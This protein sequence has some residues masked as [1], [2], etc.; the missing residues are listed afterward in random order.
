MSE[1][2]DEGVHEMI[3]FAWF[4]HN[5]HYFIAKIVYIEEVQ[6]I[7]RHRWFQVISDVNADAHMVELDIS[8]PVSA[9]IYYDI[10]SAINQ[11]N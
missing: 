4:N 6:D 5:R 2:V 7:L 9:E 8:P 11:H 3:N 1:A 10:C